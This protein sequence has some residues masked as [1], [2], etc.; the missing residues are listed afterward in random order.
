MTRVCVFK[1]LNPYG[2]LTWQT[3]AMISCQ[4]EFM[5]RMTQEWVEEKVYQFRCRVW[6][7]VVEGRHA[8]VMEHTPEKGS[9]LT[10]SLEDQVGRKGISS[11]QNTFFV[12]KEREHCK[13]DRLLVYHGEHMVWRV[14]NQSILYAKLRSLMLKLWGTTAWLIK[15]ERDIQSSF[16]TR[17]QRSQCKRTEKWRQEVQLGYNYDR[18]QFNRKKQ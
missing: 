9:D 5:P 3:S 16:L 18:G 15:L 7:L 12:E 13:A 10:I 11:A 6:W 1:E 17:S 4:G 8:G 2:G 14:G